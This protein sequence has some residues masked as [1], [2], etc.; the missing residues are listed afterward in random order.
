MVNDDLAVSSLNFNAHISNGRIFSIVAC[1]HSRHFQANAFVIRNYVAR[2]NCCLRESVLMACRIGGILGHFVNVRYYKR[3]LY[4]DGKCGKCGSSLFIFDGISKGFCKSFAF[5]EGFYSEVSVI[6]S[7]GVGTIRIDCNFTVI[8]RDCG[9]PGKWR[10]MFPLLNSYNGERITDVG[11]G[12][13]ISYVANND[14]RVRIVILMIR[15]VGAP[16][17]TVFTSGFAVGSSFVPVMVMVRVVWAYPP[18][19]SEMV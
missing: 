8:S 9:G 5:A 6:K 18:L 3:P 10:S 2:Y 19:P 13:I 15:V 7:V 12:V 11:V 14:S 4:C 1:P 17:R 16:S